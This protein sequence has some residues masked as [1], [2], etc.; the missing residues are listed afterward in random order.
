M[1]RK[2]IEK[3]ISIL[4][5]ILFLI[6][7]LSYNYFF[8][9]TVVPKTDPK[10]EIKAVEVYNGYENELTDYLGHYFMEEYS[11]TMHAHV[12]S[13]YEKDIKRFLYDFDDYTDVKSDN[14]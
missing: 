2:K 6:I 4:S 14:K 13:D 7:F 3:R 5:C 12:F 1:A 11:F 9:N 8:I 10:K